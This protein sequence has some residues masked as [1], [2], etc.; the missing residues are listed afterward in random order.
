MKRIINLSQV[1]AVK[2]RLLD[3]AEDRKT[4]FQ[5]DCI[6]DDIFRDDYSALI[7]AARFLDDFIVLSLHCVEFDK[8]IS[9]G[10]T[11]ILSYIN[12]DNKT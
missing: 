9:K 10:L 3:L 1:K 6:D 2:K 12:G 5:T 11:E 8:I 7:M 4:F